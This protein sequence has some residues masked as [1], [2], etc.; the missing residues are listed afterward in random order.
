FSSKKST[1]LIHIKTK[2]TSW[3]LLSLKLL[4]SEF[5]HQKEKTL[6]PKFIKNTQNQIVIFKSQFKF[7][8]LIGGSK[9]PY[10]GIRSLFLYQTFNFINWKHLHFYEFDF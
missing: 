10:R 6:I 5:Q 9:G 2:K 7:R 8:L 3:L 4:F 1:F